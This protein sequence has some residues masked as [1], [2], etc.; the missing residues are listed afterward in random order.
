MPREALKLCVQDSASRGIGFSYIKKSLR[1]FSMRHTYA[2]DMKKI[3]FSS[4]T[5]RE[6][7]RPSGKRFLVQKSAIFVLK[8]CNC[9]T[10]LTVVTSL[11]F[12]HKI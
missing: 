11:D 8:I 2:C 3:A 4:Y 9:D 1:D 10:K 5:P 6:A 12:M 7:I